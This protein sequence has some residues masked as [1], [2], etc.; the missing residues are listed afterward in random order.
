MSLELL[1]AMSARLRHRGRDGEASRI[2]GA[3]GFAC[4]HNWVTPEEHGEHQ[5]L[6]GRSG[7]ML[8]LDG[9]IDNRAELIAALQAGPSL[10]D[11]ALVL[12]AYDAWEAGFAERLNGDFA[13]AIFDPARERLLL[14]RDA[15]GVRPL[16]YFH[17]ARL[18]AF[19]TEIKA[20]LAHPDI[21]AVADDEGVADFMLI[22]S[23]PLDRQDITCFRGISAVVPA[24][25]ITVTPRALA[26]RRYWD[27]DTQTP[28]RFSSFEEYV[29]AFGRHFREAVK[30]R[31]RSLYPVA[32]SVSGGLDS[33][34]I[35]CQAETLRQA[36]DMTA[37]SLAGV[38]YISDRSETDEQHYL[39][40][41]AARYGSRFNTFFIEPLTGL[42]RRAE[43]QVA[44]IEAPFVDYTFGVTQELHARAAATGARSLLSGH[45][46][47]QMLFSAA[48][49]LD[50]LH[51]GAWGSIW[52]HTK[53]Y[54]RY[55]GPAETRRRRRL[56]VIDAIRHAVPG[57]MAPLLK[58]LKL[59]LFGGRRPKEWFS[60]AFLDS[61]LR[62]RYK[63]ATF[64]CRFHSAHARAVYIEARSKYHVQCM[65]WNNK[66]AAL[67]G[68]DAAFP[69]LDRDLIGFLM[70]IPG[71]MHAHG[72][73]PRVLLREAM[74]GILPDSIRART[75]KSDFTP[76][77]NMGLINDA[78][79]ILQ[80]LHAECLGVKFGYLD[81]ERLSPELARLASGLNKADCVASWNLADTYG[82]EMWLRVFL[83]PG[84]VA[85]ASLA[86]QE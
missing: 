46:G 55:F 56:L 51:H 22:G 31:S 70:A 54:A 11:A 49:L 2:D 41:I 30:R 68:L 35:F 80:T 27:F 33:S 5:P 38:S 69:F 47:D 74:H 52:H 62:H 61:A 44:T 83:D 84:R 66:V 4:Q 28:L 75:W 81:A 25:L 6:V 82:L 50:L 13:L 8:V 14:A 29:E 79:T 58:R 53:E 72:G 19:A 57:S 36:G 18:F 26:R 16:Y 7:A 32:V 42:V 76:F 23:R 39:A 40:D 63:V 12:A 59:Q 85:A 78:T 15:I 48:Y 77:V 67:Q 60:P 71:D 73:V 1:A 20:L 17:S 3:A 9:R 65:E 34:S 86:A 21:T 24:H 45:W 37:P 10:S 43:Q 64:E